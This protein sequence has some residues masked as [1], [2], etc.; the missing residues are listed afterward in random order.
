[1]NRIVHF[2]FI[3]PKRTFAK[4][5]CYIGACSYLNFQKRT[6]F[7][8]F[9]SVFILRL[10]WQHRGSAAEIYGTV[11]KRSSIVSIAHN[12]N[13][14]ELQSVLLF[15]FL[16]SAYI[17]LIPS[18]SFLER[19]QLSDMVLAKDFY[20][21]WPELLL[22]NNS[23]CAWFTYTPCIPIFYDYFHLTSNPYH[24]LPVWTTA[25]FLL[26][27]RRPNIYLVFLYQISSDWF[28]AYL[29]CISDTKG[30]DGGLKLWACA[31]A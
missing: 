30:C 11:R 16:F 15:K 18:I 22:N 26:F 29:F 5:Q 6:F 17:D 20:K 12:C 7:G 8:W 10:E 3:N 28:P 27:T 24:V 4:T 14:A 23:S 19:Q 1:M 31:A 21:T 9:C 2:I 13:T 25:I